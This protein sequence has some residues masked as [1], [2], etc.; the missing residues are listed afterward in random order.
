LRRR[1]ALLWANKATSSL[2]ESCE[3]F[4]LKN[5]YFY[6]IFFL[7]TPYWKSYFHPRWYDNI[8]KTFLWR[9]YDIFKMSF[10][11]ACCQGCTHPAN[12]NEFKWTK[13]DSFCSCQIQILIFLIHFYPIKVSEFFKI[14]FNP[15]E[16]I[17]TKRFL[18]F[19]I[20]K[21]YPNH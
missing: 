3:D 4:V 7:F 10:K 15:Y 21:K 1:I 12:E 2:L 16:G 8:Q 17:K 9:L 18:F 5:V 20:K 6:S 19:S 14:H 13:M 11:H